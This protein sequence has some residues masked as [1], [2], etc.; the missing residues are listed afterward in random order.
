[1][2]LKMLRKLLTAVSAV[3]IIVAGSEHSLFAEAIFLKDGSIISG[4]IISDAASSVSL[5]LSDNKIKQI[6]RSDIMRILYT[7]LKMGKIYIQ[8]RDGKGVVAFMVDED[9]QSY[10]F[11]K[12]LYNPEEFVLKRSEVLFISEKNPS[13]LQVV[14]E[15]GTDRVSLEW[16]PPYD[17]VKRYNLYM[18]KSEK[19]KYEM[20]ESTGSK[21]IKLK[22]LSPKTNYY[23]MVTSVDKEDYESSPSNELK[24]TTSARVDV[25]LKDGKTFKTYLVIDDQNAYTFKDNLDDK[26][27]KVVKKSDVLYITERYP[28][29]LRGNADTGSIELEWFAPYD[30]MNV[31]NIYTKKKGEEYQLASTSSGNSYTLKGLSGNTEYT[32]KVTGVGNDKV[33]TKSSNELKLSTRNTPPAEAVITAV[34]KLDTGEL[35]ITWTAATD[36]DGKVELY[37]IYGKKDDKRELISE[38]K[39]T[40]YTLKDFESYDK[41]ELV[42]VDD[43]GDESDSVKVKVAS[44]GG[45]TALGFTPGVIIPLGKFGEMADIGYGGMLCLTERNLY[46]D[47][48]ETGI[49]TGFYYA[50]GKDRIKE[51]KPLF[52]R[53]LIAPLLI[54][55]GYRFNFWESFSVIPTISLGAAYFNMTYLKYDSIKMDEEITE[56]FVDPMVKCGVGIEY[57]ITESFSVS[58]IS[59]YGMFIE[60]SGP[61]EFITA[62]IG[63]NYRF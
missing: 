5:R 40:E 26:E 15:V 14:G 23:L 58:L 8:K 33:E 1:M 63:V 48:F 18:K 39:K 27:D 61:M 11:R 17:A 30:P 59:E 57:S 31:Y 2:K 55:A 42:A 29:A 62:G 10:T 49:G 52:H 4:S 9:Q 45:E 43:K 47:G 21:S 24:I 35:S 37:R 32:I 50:E 28:S 13:G 56:N 3:A 12:E 36:N 7:E 38:L 46:F 34:V 41:V 25:Q 54:N 20:V 53:F 22:N 60:M 44:G 16:Q 51:G 6:P 19:D